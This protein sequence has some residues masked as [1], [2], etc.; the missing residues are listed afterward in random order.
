MQLQS[1][2]LSCSRDT[3]DSDATACIDLLESL[4]NCN[5]RI[6]ATGMCLGGHLA[7]R[8][9][10]DP[11]IKAACCFFPTDIHSE[12]LGS[13]GPSDSMKRC[14]EIKGE[15]L[16]IL[17]VNDTHVVSI[18]PLRKTCAEQ[19][20]RSSLCKEGTSCETG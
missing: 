11:R 7:F 6:A 16:M 13:P 15:L 10:L 2:A 9:A 8:C 18:L 20:D 3:Q 19:Y 14:E 4:P 17:G 1:I 12:S 5:G